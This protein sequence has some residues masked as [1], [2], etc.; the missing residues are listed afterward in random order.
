[1]APSAHHPALFFIHEGIS[2]SDSKNGFNASVP[3]IST[4]ESPPKNGITIV[5][6]DGVVSVSA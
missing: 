6:Y 5:L 3:M 4:T 2:I 1:M